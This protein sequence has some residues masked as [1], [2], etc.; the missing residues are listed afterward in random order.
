MRQYDDDNV[1][2]RQCDYDTA[3]VRLRQCENTM[4]TVRQLDMAPK[5]R[6]FA[7]LVSGLVLLFVS[8]GLGFGFTV[9]LPG[10]DKRVRRQEVRGRTN[11]GLVSVT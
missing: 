3:I 2:V 8:V 6:K 7:V 10:T 5:W 4:P 11:S 9:M 1:T